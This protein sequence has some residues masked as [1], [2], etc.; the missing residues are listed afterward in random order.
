MQAALGFG[1]AFDTPPIL[2]GLTVIAAGTSLSDAFVSVR[3]ARDNGGVTSLAN[4][5]G[6]NTFG[7]LVALPVGVLLAGAATIDFAVAVPTF[8]VLTAATVLR[9]TILRTDL[10]VSD[11]EAYALLTA[12]AGFVGW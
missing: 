5:L 6:S 11:R 10:A 9:F 7:L 4:V 12:Y 3:A 2:W 8:G 1:R